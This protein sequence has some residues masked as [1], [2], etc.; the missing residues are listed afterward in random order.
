MQAQDRRLCCSRSHTTRQHDSRDR[1]SV[2]SWRKVGFARS[3]SD[4][5]TGVLLIQRPWNRGI[6]RWERQRPRRGLR[7]KNLGMGKRFS[8][9]PIES[10]SANAN[11]VLAHPQPSPPADRPPR[12]EHRLLRLICR[13]NS[14]NRRVA[15]DPRRRHRRGRHGYVSGRKWRATPAAPPAGGDRSSA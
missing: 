5:R 14:G 3:V 8:L 2:S 12:A 11:S 4:K 9:T 6:D 13:R 15:R 7:S 10:R 1:S